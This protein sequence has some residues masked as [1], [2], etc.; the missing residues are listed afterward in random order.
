MSMAGLDRCA[1]GAAITA[2][3]LTTGDLVGSGYDSGF[4]YGLD[5]CQRV[6]ERV[7]DSLNGIRRALAR[8]SFAV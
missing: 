7:W 2:A 1:G 6:S 8:S 3:L 4:K 5:S